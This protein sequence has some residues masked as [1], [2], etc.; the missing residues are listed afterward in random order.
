[1]CERVRRERVFRKLSERQRD[2]G[3][4]PVSAFNR[5]LAQ[6]AGNLLI[7]SYVRRDFSREGGVERTRGK[8][9]VDSHA[10]CDVFES[11]VIDKAVSVYFTEVDFPK[12]A[13]FVFFPCDLEV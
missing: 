10:V 2:G 12:L 6:P 9:R 11:I 7:L 3:A 1:M 13:F 8:L 5:K 4:R